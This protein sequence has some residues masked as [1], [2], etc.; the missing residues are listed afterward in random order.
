[1]SKKS[2]SSDQS[3]KFAVKD[4]KTAIRDL[5]GTLGRANVDLLIYELELYDLRLQNDLAEYGLAEIK[6][7][8]EKIF[9]DASPLLLERI[10]KVLNE[11]TTWH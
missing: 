6:I 1:L 4:I 5:E 2:S 8:F 9:G 3:I 7:A 10:I 11:P